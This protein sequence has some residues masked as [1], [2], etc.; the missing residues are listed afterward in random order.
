M[1]ESQKADMSSIGIIYRERSPEAAA[2]AL[3]LTEQ[4]RTTGRRVWSS[5]RG[6]E[7]YIRGSL[8]DTGTVFVLGGDG[9][10]LSVHGFALRPTFP[11]WASTLAESAFLPSLS[12]EK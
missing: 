5:S 12:R 2:L 10:I 1:S 11:S 9:T 4:L 8:P 6:Q 3:L 7:G